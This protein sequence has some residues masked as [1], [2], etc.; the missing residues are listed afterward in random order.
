[1]SFEMLL[2]NQRDKIFAI[3]TEKIECYWGTIQN[4][5]T[6]KFAYNQAI[7]RLALALLQLQKIKKNFPLI[8]AGGNSN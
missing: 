4:L 6:K 3:S 1:M 5:F 2:S 7:I 8:K